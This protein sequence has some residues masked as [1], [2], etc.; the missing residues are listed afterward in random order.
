MW[1]N[2][3]LLDPI[4]HPTRPISTNFPSKNKPKTRCP[5]CLANYQLLDQSN[6]L[7]PNYTIPIPNTITWVANLATLVTT[8]FALCVTLRF[9]L[10]VQHFPLRARPRTA[11]RRSVDADDAWRLHMGPIYPCP[12]LGLLRS[13]PCSRCRAAHSLA[14]VYGKVLLS[15]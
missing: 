4:I 8:L 7:G 14:C 3:D 13:D 15:H 11:Y 2:N 5:I 6:Y 1:S 9:L 10:V 12:G